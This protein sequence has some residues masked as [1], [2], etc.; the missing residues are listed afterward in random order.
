[1]S[2]R[3]GVL[4]PTFGEGVS[5]ERLFGFTD[6]LESLGFG[7]VWARDQVGFLG[8]HAFEADIA[9]F[10][11]PYVTLSAIAARNQRLVL[12]FAPIIPFRHPVVVAQLIGSLAFLAGDR[13]I[14][15]MGAGTPRRPFEL[16]GIPYESRFERIRETAEVLRAL[17]HPPA[18]YAGEFASFENLTIDPPP[19]ADLEL[20]YGGTTFK[21]VERALA[22][23]TGWLPGRCPL[24]VLDE[25]LARL[26]DGADALGKRMRTGIIPIVSL[27]RDRETALARIP[28]A[29][30]LEEANKKKQWAKVGP[31]ETADDMRGAVIAGGAD[32]VAAELRQLADRGIDEVILD[33]RLR[34]DA[35]EES[36][37]R[38]S[39]EV[40]PR[41]VGSNAA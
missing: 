36:L 33:L 2:M 41:L 15:G 7:S 38:I 8:G 12:G 32:D 27:D 10:V 39:E 23:G 40:L 4:L 9:S 19:P 17:A 3:V 28:M 20:W 25:K 18:T 16:T 31:F 24:P 35:Y 26:R 11:D 37:Q 30:L 29:G 5:H 22:F 21:S 14:V 34:P 13:L 1:M 6:R